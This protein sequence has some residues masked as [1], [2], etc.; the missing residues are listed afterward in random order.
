MNKF[1]LLDSINKRI[2]KAKQRVCSLINKHNNP[3][4]V[5]SKKADSSSS[6]ILNRHVKTLQKKSSKCIQT[7]FDF[8]HQNKC[9]S[10]S[11]T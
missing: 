10:L 9:F 1:G 11:Q 6:N 5:I 3:K 8:M 2:K 4:T 7:R